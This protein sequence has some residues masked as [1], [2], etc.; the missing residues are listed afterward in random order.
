MLVGMKMRSRRNRSFAVLALC[1]GAAACHPGKQGLPEPSK[2]V[3]KLG[4]LIGKWKTKSHRLAS[5][6]NDTAGESELNFTC[7]WTLDKFYVACVQMGEMSGQKVKE[8]DLFGYS[9]KAEL[10]SMLVVLDIGDAAPRTYTNWF[11]W[12]K[13]VWR[14]QP[15]NG[16]RS[17]W[18][19]KSP[20]YHVTQTE[21]SVDGV[22]WAVS[23]TSEHFRVP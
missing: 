11:A 1:L 19:F 4:Q 18:E 22:N 6:L 9:E 15:L 2:E 8:V 21:R 14:F 10:Y 12:D 17:T 7:S 3:V 13:N 5:S 16:V 23:S 20:D